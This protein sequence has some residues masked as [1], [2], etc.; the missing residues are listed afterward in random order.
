MSI[1]SQAKY[2]LQ[3]INFGEDDSEAMIEI[4]RKFFRQWD[5]GGAVYAVTPILMKLIAGK[6]LSPLTGEADE[7]NEVGEGILQNKRMSSVF[8]DPRFHNGELAYD[9]DNREDPRGAITFP[10]TPKRFEVSSP[11]VSIET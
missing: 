3:K 7:W 10:Y 4:L 8:K 1:I 9:I 11:V 5:S 6:P 2:E